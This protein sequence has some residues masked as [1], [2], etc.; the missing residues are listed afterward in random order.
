MES[1]LSATAFLLKP[2]E[3]LTAFMDLAYC[4]ILADRIWKRT[5]SFFRYE[6]GTRSMLLKMFPFLMISSN[7]YKSGFCSFIKESLYQSNYEYD[8]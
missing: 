1:I 6:V 8:I 4:F 3:S 2:K 7:F 5:K